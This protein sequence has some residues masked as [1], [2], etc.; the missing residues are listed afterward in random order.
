VNTTITEPDGF[1][2]GA[3]LNFEIDGVTYSEMIHLQDTDYF[4]LVDDLPLAPTAGINVYVTKDN[5]KESSF[6]YTKTSEVERMNSVRIEFINRKWFDTNTGV[7]TNQ[8]Q[9]DVVEQDQP[10]HYINDSGYAT[11]PIDSS[12]QRQIRLDGVKRKSQAMRLLNFFANCNSYLKY[13]CEFTTDMVGYL[14]R[15]GDIIGVS[16]SSIGW[17]V[18]EFRIVGLEEVEKDEIKISCLEY[19]RSI[20]GDEIPVVFSSSTSIIPSVYAVPDDIE[21]FNVVQDLTENVIYFN[22]KR[23]DDNAWWGGAEIWV[24]KG[25]GGEY[26]LAGVYLA[27]AMSIKLDTGGIDAS[28]TYV[29][30]DSTTLYG[31]FPASGE[32]WIEDEL[33]SYTSINETLNQFEGCTRGTNASA[34]ADTEYCNLKESNTPY[35]NF[36]DADIGSTWYFKAVSIT[37]AGIPSDIDTATELSLTLS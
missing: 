13:Y 21:R 23:P 24:K 35:T 3:Y 26:E 6:N 30:F 34:H 4:D 2:E 11:H 19:N 25:V 20:Y 16:H 18:K 36:A 32:F 27:T 1:W 8:Y 37:V 28:Q 14:H 5:I 15:I 7:E 9:W 31:E 12:N 17:V 10:E 22:F 29:P 33:I